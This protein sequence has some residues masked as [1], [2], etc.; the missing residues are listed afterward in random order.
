MCMCITNRKTPDKML[1]TRVNIFQ[2][3]QEFQE[4]YNLS[5]T[6]LPQ[7]SQAYEIIAQQMSTKTNSAKQWHTDEHLNQ[8]VFIEVLLKLNVKN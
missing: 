2:T 4:Q 6:H 1:L 7:N 3:A 5:T 8:I